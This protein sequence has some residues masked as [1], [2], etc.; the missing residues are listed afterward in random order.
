MSEE[1][2]GFK[3]FLPTVAVRQPFTVISGIIEIDHGGHSIYPQPVDVVF[4]KPKKGIG[5]QVVTHLVPAVVI[6]ISAPFRM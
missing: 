3:I 4:I 2:D 5:Y 1:F 6:D